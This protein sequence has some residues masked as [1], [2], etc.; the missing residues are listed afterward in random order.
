MRLS[1]YERDVRREIDSWQHGNISL[2]TQAINWAMSPVDWVVQQIIPDDLLDHDFSCC[3]SSFAESIM[4]E[5]RKGPAVR[6]GRFEIIS[7][8][9]WTR[10]LSED[11][12]VQIAFWTMEPLGIQ[13]LASEG[14]YALDLEGHRSR[15]LLEL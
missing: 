11:G 5:V 3:G 10:L 8:E 2:L 13:V 12:P 6:C 14:R 9:K 1:Q 15:E 7:I 4:E